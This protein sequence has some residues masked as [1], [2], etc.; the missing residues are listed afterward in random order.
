LRAFYLSALW[1]IYEILYLLLRVQERRFITTSQGAGMQASN[2]SGCKKILL[3]MGDGIL[4]H[5][6]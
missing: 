2:S 1:Q 4:T 5:L 3:Y 6:P